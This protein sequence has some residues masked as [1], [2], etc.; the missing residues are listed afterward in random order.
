MLAVV[1]HAIAS[2]IAAANTITLFVVP[3]ASPATPA[4]ASVERIV[5]ARPEPLDH[6]VG[7]QARRDAC[8]SRRR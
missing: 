4:R 6:A 2:A 1:P 8:R 5:R 3:A 7:R